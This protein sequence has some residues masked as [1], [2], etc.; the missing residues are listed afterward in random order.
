M[1][2]EVKVEQLISKNL[3]E[4]TAKELSRQINKCLETLAPAEC[5]Q[6]ISQKILKPSYPFELH[7]FLYHYTLFVGLYPKN[8]SS[9]QVHLPL[10]SATKTAQV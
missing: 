8:I 6:K 5:W 4:S 7:W 10:W 2:K 9:N 1:I 3:D